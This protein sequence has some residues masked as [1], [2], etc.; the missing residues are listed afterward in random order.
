[1]TG[2]PHKLDHIGIRVS[3]L[4]ASKKFYTRAL[5]P[6]GISLLGSSEQHAAFGTGPMPYLTVRLT[7]QPPVSVHV[8]FVAETRAQVDAFYAAALGAGGTDNGPPGLR[9]DYHPDYYGAF[10]RDP[11]GHNIEVVK[12]TPE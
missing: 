9:P 5:Q 4:A 2:W 1:M 10:V 6:I 3:D 8:A 12:H 11:D 7:D